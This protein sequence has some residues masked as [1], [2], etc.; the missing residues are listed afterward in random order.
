MGLFRYNRFARRRRAI[1]HT[2]LIMPIGSSVGL[3]KGHAVTKRTLKPR[4]SRR[5]GIQGKRVGM[6]RELVSEV[7]GLAP[8]EKRLVELLKVGRDKRALKSAKKKLGTHLRAK[9]KREEMQ[10]FLRKSRK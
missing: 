1:F 2:S 5:K 7:V 9:H 4:P 6:I 3:E 10:N 8:Y